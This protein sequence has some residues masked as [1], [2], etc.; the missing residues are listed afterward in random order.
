MAFSFA[1][2]TLA[3]A[4]ATDGAARVDKPAAVVNRTSGGDTFHGTVHGA[5]ET[6]ALDMERGAG[7]GRMAARASN[8]RSGDS[9]V[10]EAVSLLAEQSSIALDA[11][12]PRGGPGKRRRA[13]RKSDVP[14]YLR[15]DFPTTK[16]LF[17]PTEHDL[18]LNASQMLAELEEGNI[19]RVAR[20]PDR[21]GRRRPRRKPKGR[22]PAE[23]SARSPGHPASLRS[24]VDDLLGTGPPRA[25]A[26]APPPPAAGAR[27]A[28]AAAAPAPAAELADDATAATLITARASY[29]DFSALPEDSTFEGS[30]AERSAIARADGVAGDRDDQNLDLA[31]L[32]SDAASSVRPLYEG[33]NAVAAK[34][35]LYAPTY[36]WCQ[37][38]IDQGCVSVVRPASPRLARETPVHRRRL[39][40]MTSL[41]K[42]KGKPERHVYSKD[43]RRALDRAELDRRSGTSRPNF[44]IIELGQIEVDSAD[45]WTDR[46]L[47]SISRRRAEEPVS[48]RSTTRAPRVE[49]ASPAQVLEK[50]GDVAARGDARLLEEKDDEPRPEADDMIR[51]AA[52]ELGG[53]RATLRVRGTARS[54]GR[55]SSIFEPAPADD[56]DDDDEGDDA[57]DGDGFETTHVER[58]KQQSWGQTRDARLQ[59][60]ATLTASRISRAASVLARRDELR[61]EQDAVLQGIIN[62]HILKAEVEERNE[63]ASKWLMLIANSSRIL[64]L[65]S[66]HRDKNLRLAKS[67]MCQAAAIVVQRAYLDWQRRR[68][69]ALHASSL[70]VVNRVVAN[71]VAWRRAV[72]AEERRLEAITI[73]QF[74]MRPNYQTGSKVRRAILRFRYRV[75]R[76]QRFARE[77]LKCRESRLSG[78]SRIWVHVEHVLYH[79]TAGTTGYQPGDRKNGVVPRPGK[80][81]ADALRVAD[82]S[83]ARLTGRDSFWHV[84]RE[85]RMRATREIYG[86][87]RIAHRDRVDVYLSS[88]RKMTGGVRSM[89]MADARKFMSSSSEILLSDFAVLADARRRPVFPVF[90]S[91]PSHMIAAIHRAYDKRRERR[92]ILDPAYDRSLLQKVESLLVQE[93]TLRML[94]QSQGSST[95]SSA[96][97]LSTKTLPAEPPAPGVGDHRAPSPTHS[98][99][100]SDPSQISIAASAA[101]AVAKPGGGRATMLAKRGAGKERESPN[102][103]G[104]DLGRFPLVLADFWTSDHLAERSRSVHAF[105]GTR[106]RGTP[107]LKRI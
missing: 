1:T 65:R 12:V 62:K 21:S 47:S 101:S 56:D 20:R 89:T 97:S 9:V 41:D 102:F 26:E 73:I 79:Q 83:A 99:L 74:I 78:L 71:F 13:T 75:L 32:G 60:R 68:T 19:R 24:V 63:V 80:A 85:A 7:T 11:A 34:R 6:A 8:P 36:A 88:A 46:W 82:G 33:A 61:R 81:V 37:K 92:K 5:A 70:E 28:G 23:A 48:N 67:P 105:S 15:A 17:A 95:Y 104:S 54:A 30:L 44:E 69:H 103:K 52:A 91:A 29:D 66:W 55:R 18:R 43:E 76:C 77:F 107:T 4:A 22:A 53:A 2:A 3:S 25:A 100:R 45:V 51:D 96:A 98:A 31:T 84:P 86:R 49:D 14:A 40:V 16:W 42:N 94:V 59:R 10:S 72:R 106:A 64:T 87:L 50:I 38:L 58:N 57:F 39:A 90:R 35:S 27:G 93:S